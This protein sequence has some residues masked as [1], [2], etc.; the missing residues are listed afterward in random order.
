MLDLGYQGINQGEIIF[1]KIRRDISSVNTFQGRTL[2]EIFFYI[3]NVYTGGTGKKLFFFE[4]NKKYFYMQ[5]FR[6]L[7]SYFLS[8][9]CVYT[10]TYFKR[11]VEIHLFSCF[12]Y[13]PEV[14]GMKKQ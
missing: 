4:K 7:V 10:T 6:H 2:I 12:L 11:S 1:N 8:E 5:T 9:K 3:C 13:L 14:N